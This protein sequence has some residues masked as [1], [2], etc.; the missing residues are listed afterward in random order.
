[1]QKKSLSVRCGEKKTR[2]ANWRL[3]IDAYP[4]LF[5]TP[6][7]FFLT[8][9]SPTLYLLPPLPLRRLALFFLYLSPVLQSQFFSE[10][11]SQ[12]ERERGMH[13]GW[14]KGREERAWFAWG[15]RG[16]GG[17]GEGGSSEA[18]RRRKRGA[19]R[20]PKLW[21]GGGGGDQEGGSLLSQLPSPSRVTFT[22]WRG[23]ASHWITRNVASSRDEPWGGRNVLFV[24]TDLIQRQQAGM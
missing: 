22:V 1:M 7:F 12:R 5:P 23:S 19:E 14:E 17:G 21:K 13:V 24:L 20:G 4:R 3:Q 18:G 9:P 16:G 8:P 15:E 11:V 2:G 6:F 10:G